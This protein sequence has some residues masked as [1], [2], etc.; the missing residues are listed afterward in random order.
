MINYVFLGGSHFG[1]PSMATPVNA[2][3]KWTL[4]FEPVGLKNVF[5]CDYV[6]IGWLVIDKLFFLWWSF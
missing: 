6:T 3:V 1:F 2:T 5:N 4:Y